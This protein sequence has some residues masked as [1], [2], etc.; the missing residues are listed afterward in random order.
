MKNTDRIAS[1]AQDFLPRTAGE[2]YGRII[3]VDPVSRG[4]A[5]AMGVGSMFWLILAL[6]IIFVKSL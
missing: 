1:I 5:I 2:K 3:E 4:F 6:I